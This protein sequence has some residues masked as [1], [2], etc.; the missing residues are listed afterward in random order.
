VEANP[1]GEPEVLDTKDPRKMRKAG[2]GLLTLYTVPRA[3]VFDG[4]TSLGTTPLMKVPLPAGT[5]RLRVVDPDGTSRMFSGVVEVAK[6][7]K[8]TIKVSDLPP[9]GE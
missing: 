2:I 8:Y 3:A 5:Y 7:N 1:D 4:Q 6:D 9:Y